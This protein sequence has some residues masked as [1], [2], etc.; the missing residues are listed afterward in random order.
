MT[1]VVAA[2][3]AVVA[4][5][6]LAVAAGRP[7]LAPV[8]A[9]AAP[10]ALGVLRAR[11]AARAAA[12]AE[13][14]LARAAPDAAD[15]IAAAL[16]AG[17]LLDLAVAAAG[18]ALPGRL[19]GLLRAAGEGDDRELAASV[20]LRPLT[21]ALRQ[22]RELGSP[23]ADD[24]R[25]LA[26]DLRASLAAAAREEAAAAGVRATLAVGLLVAPG[27]L[28]VVLAVEL[29]SIGPLLAP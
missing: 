20:A 29:A 14:E 6:L 23:V 3:V 2:G 12:S 18:R 1:G 8:T 4:G 19:G 10:I 24:L 27:A 16:A 9:P 25:Q 26:D 28:I 22:S 11:V 15:L 13:R 17:V 7:W 5:L 21:A